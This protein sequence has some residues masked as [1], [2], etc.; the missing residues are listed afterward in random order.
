MSVVTE[1]KSKQDFKSFILICAASSDFNISEEEHDFI[2]QLIPEER[3]KTLKRIADR[4]SDFECVNIIAEH[5]D[6]Y[7]RTPQEKEALLQEIVELF[8]SDHNYSTLERNM[9]LAIKRI[10]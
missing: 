6:D 1:I 5:K 8:K 9:L 3:Y 2:I 7:L 10:L 4:C